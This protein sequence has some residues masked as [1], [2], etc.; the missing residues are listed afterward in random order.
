MKKFVLL[1]ALTFS[2]GFAVNQSPANASGWHR[3]LPKSMMHGYYWSGWLHKHHYHS[4]NDYTYLRFH[5]R[6]LELYDGDG[7]EMVHCQYRSYD[8]HYY[9]IYGKFEPGYR[10]WD[11]MFF[12]VSNSRKTIYYTPA[13]SNRELKKIGNNLKWYKMHRIS[14]LPR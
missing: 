13:Y 2:L 11:N 12:Q 1:I 6:W 3:G 4:G 9:Q 10:T 5:K 14:H 8:K 7:A